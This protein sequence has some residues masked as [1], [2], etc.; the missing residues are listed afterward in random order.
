[1]LVN[2]LYSNLTTF[3]DLYI[4]EGTI[5]WYNP[6][7]KIWEETLLKKLVNNPKF[8]ETLDIGTQKCVSNP[9]VFNELLELINKI[10]HNT[11]ILDKLDSNRQIFSI[12]GGKVVDL[13]NNVIRDRTKED[14]C[15]FFINVDYLEN[16]HLNEGEYYLRSIIDDEDYNDYVT[17]LANM[18]FG[19][20]GKP[21]V[22]I[23][24]KGNNGKTGLVEVIEKILGPYI[25]RGYINHDK[26]RVIY[27][28][29]C[30]I[31]ENCSILKCLCEGDNSYRREINKAGQQVSTNKAKV[32][33]VTNECPY[34]TVPIETN[35]G[36]WN[37]IELLEFKKTFDY[38]SR[39][40]QYVRW[41]NEKC[42]DQIFT[43]FV[44]AMLR[45]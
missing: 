24:G 23:C 41:V 43:I 45:K 1:M 39:D 27:W 3:Y 18:L 2:R 20:A 44:N 12:N 4:K 34:L 8:Y 5:Y 38:Y 15:S 21:I 14:Y 19:V 30:D 40:P 17:V 9:F 25:V 13:S 7:L 29:E 42:L 36:L 28:P 26:Q 37:R 33:I 35:G 6:E 22:V 10:S 11:D 32:L 31:R 16:H